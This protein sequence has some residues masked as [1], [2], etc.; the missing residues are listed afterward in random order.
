MKLNTSHE[1]QAGEF[2]MAAMSDLAFLLIIFFMVCGHFVDQ[3]SS[4]VELPVAGTGDE[5]DEMP[6]MVTITGTGSYEVNDMSVPAGDIEDELRGRVRMADTPTGKTVLL[7]AERSL[8]YGALRVVVDAV[9]K[10]G[11]MLELA[12]LEE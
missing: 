9:N 2:S 8:D 7:R 12:V 1:V 6:I 4:S 3:S 10:S 5:G 11:G